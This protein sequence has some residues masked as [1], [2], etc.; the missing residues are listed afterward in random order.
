M[1]WVA[2]HGWRC[3]VWEERDL[4]QLAMLVGYISIFPIQCDIT[5]QT[6]VHMMATFT[7]M[8]ALNIHLLIRRLRGESLC[9]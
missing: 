5:L 6:I 7:V 4:G 8:P 1:V 2:W 3:L 9:E